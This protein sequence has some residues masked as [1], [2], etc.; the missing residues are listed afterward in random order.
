MF[1]VSLTIVTF[2]IYSFDLIRNSINSRASRSE[3]SKLLDEINVAL[4][5]AKERS[6]VIEKVRI[7]WSRKEESLDLQ[8][9]YNYELDRKY[10]ELLYRYGWNKL[11]IEEYEKLIE[12]W[13][14]I[15]EEYNNFSEVKKILSEWISPDTKLFMANQD[16][17]IEALIEQNSSGNDCLA[18]SF[19]SERNK[20][21]LYEQKQ[22]LSEKKNNEYYYQEAQEHINSF[23]F[24]KA[25]EVYCQ[26]SEDY[27]N[28]PDIQKQLQGWLSN[29]SELL[30]DEREKV[31]EK[32]TELKNNCPVS[33]LNN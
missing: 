7:E 9:P 25:V 19:K 4:G 6:R 17:V 11:N 1:V 21:R 32:L 24:E 22:K 23:E 2:G 8:C 13:C 30:D 14:E 28:F 12:A 5:N 26:I 29:N 20:N 3:C 31:R 16:K 33:P 10:N 15:T 27:E 18:Y